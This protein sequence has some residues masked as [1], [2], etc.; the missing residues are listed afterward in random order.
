MIYKRRVF[1]V[2]VVSGFACACGWQNKVV[3]RSS[4]GVTGIEI[5]QPFPLNEAG[6]RVIL[7]R[8]AGDVTLYTE[9]ADTVLSF[10]DAVWVKEEDSVA[11]FACIGSRSIREAY[12]LTRNAPIPFDSLRSNLARKIRNEYKVA[13]DPDDPE[14]VFTWACSQGEHA[15]FQRYPSARAF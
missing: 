7:K 1:A 11:V 2:L 14:S 5:Q 9:R 8:R 10:A 13:S 6:V 12:S 15:F 3:F 4:S